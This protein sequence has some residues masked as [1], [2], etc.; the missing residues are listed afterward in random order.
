MRFCDLFVE[1]K[2][3]LDELSKDK[4]VKRVTPWW[5]NVLYLLL[6]VV[7]ADMLIFG[8]TNWWEA[9]CVSLI[10]VIVLSIAIPAIDSRV[11]MKERLETRCKPYSEKRMYMVIDL[12]MQY[13]VDITDEKVL[14][15]LIQQA[16]QAQ[17][18]KD[19]IIAYN[20][21]LKVFLGLIM[22]ATGCLAT[23]YIDGLQ[24][25]VLMKIAIFILITTIFGFVLILVSDL[26]IDLVR[27]ISY[28]DYDKYNDLI[29]DL[30][31]IQIFYK[32]NDPTI[33][34]IELGKE[35]GRIPS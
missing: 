24:K 6:V 32:N 22:A 16:Q 21:R 29:D 1:Y 5:I 31:Q 3:R 28:S 12:L 30:R 27:R 14:N 8:L 33:K 20:K 10:V 18:D 9:F 34:A 7:L 35:A 13:C 26:L 2:I 11:C 25:A 19:V 17:R 15:M 4:D 23:E